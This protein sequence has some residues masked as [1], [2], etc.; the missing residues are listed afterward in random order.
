M[1]ILLFWVSIRDNLGDIKEVGEQVV[2]VIFE[3]I[4]FINLFYFLFPDTLFGLPL[5]SFFGDKFYV[6]GVISQLEALI[7]LDWFLKIFFESLDVISS[8]EFIILFFFKF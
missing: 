5:I 1:K 7:L 8:F 3:F 6:F 2:F 4:T